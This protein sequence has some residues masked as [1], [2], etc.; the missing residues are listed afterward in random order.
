MK[1][2]LPALFAL[3]A[4]LVFLAAAIDRV[5]EAPRPQGFS[6]E[7]SADARAYRQ[8]CS[9]CHPLYSPRSRTKEEWPGL[10]EQMH[11]RAN[12]FGI[13]QDAELLELAVEYLVRF[14]R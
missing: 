9:R 7:E 4:A 11:G 3:I 13:E 2:L 10:V 14:G 12:A 5:R 1:H 6:P 8:L